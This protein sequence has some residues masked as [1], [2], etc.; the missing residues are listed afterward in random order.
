M[1]RNFRYSQWYDF[2]DIIFKRLFVKL[3]ATTFRDS[4]VDE[5]S[6]LLEVLQKPIHS[7]DP[8][9]LVS[10]DLYNCARNIIR[11]KKYRR[12]MREMVKV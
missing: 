3:L 6:S 9:S 5:L 1:Y 2:D 4:L 7:A 10:F 11:H 12:E 8:T